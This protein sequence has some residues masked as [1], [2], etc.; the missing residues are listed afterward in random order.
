[1]IKTEKMS[2][3]ASQVPVIPGHP[4]LA[5]A[6]T[7]INCRNDMLRLSFGIMILELNIFNM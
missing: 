7:L 1:V 5:I 2:N 6:N 3:V 4:F